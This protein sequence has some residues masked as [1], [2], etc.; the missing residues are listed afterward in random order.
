MNAAIFS[1]TNFR[2]AALASVVALGAFGASNGFAAEASA[3]A[4]ATVI[5]PISITNEEPLIFG[6]FT[7]VAGTV[8]V[9]TSGDRTTTGPILSTVGDTPG[10]ARFDVV[11]EGASTY[12]ITWSADAPLTN[13]TGVGGETMALSKISDLTG[14]GAISGSVGAGTLNSG[15]QSIY[16]GGVLTVD[17]AQV[18]GAYEGSVTATVEYN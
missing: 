4:S 16:L 18:P 17:A 6:S 11:G 5:I 13:T 14:G 8:T 12:G 1:R 3:P 15:V 10:A 2:R 9:S 7:P